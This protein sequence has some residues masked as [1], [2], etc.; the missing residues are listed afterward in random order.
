MNQ[1]TLKPGGKL[2]P[3][4]HE[5]VTGGPSVWGVKKTTEGKV[6]FL[7]HINWRWHNYFA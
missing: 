6:T 5:Y 1:I 3:V 7:T 4:P 2:P